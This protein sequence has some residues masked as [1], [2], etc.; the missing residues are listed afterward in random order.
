[1]QPC[2]QPTDAV[3]Y[4]ARVSQPKQKL[5]QQWTIVDTWLKQQGIEIDDHLKYE[6]KGYRRHEAAIRPAFQRLLNYAAEGRLDWVVIASFDRWGVGDVDEFFFYRR[7]LAS[8][9]VR[10]WSVQD[11]LEL[12]S[13]HDNDFWRIIGQAQANTQGMKTHAG[14]NLRKMIEMTL[15]GWHAS[16]QHPYGTDLL[17]CNLSD[18]QPIFRVHLVDKQKKKNVYKIIDCTT[19]QE[20][21]SNTMPSRDCKTTGYRLV[22][23]LDTRRIEAVQL[24]YDTFLQGLT[25]GA[26]ADYLESQGY[27]YFG[28]R[29]GW[30]TIDAILRNPTYTGYL[31]WGKYAYGHYKVLQNGTPVDTP[32]KKKNERVHPMRT[33]EECV[34]SREQIF[35]PLIT[36][37]Q[38]AAVEV[39]LG[40]REGANYKRPRRR[41]QRIH[42]L[43]GL[44]VCPDCD[45]FMVSSWGTKRD[46]TRQQYY[47]CSTYMKSR[48]KECRANSVSVDKLDKAADEVLSKVKTKLSALAA[49]D[50]STTKKL[51]KSLQAAAALAGR[52]MLDWL[53]QILSALPDDLQVDMP[54][55]FDPTSRSEK[56]MQAACSVLP[57][58]L[59]LYEEQYS[60]N[61][62]QARIAE[63]DHEIEKI[64]D[65]MEAAQS[66]TLAKR[67]V[68]TLQKLEQEKTLLTS[69]QD[70]LAQ[71]FRQQAAQASDLLTRLEELETSEVSTL[72]RTFLQKVIPIMHLVE[73]R[74]GKTRTNVQGFNFVPKNAIDSTISDALVFQSVRKG[75]DLTPQ[76]T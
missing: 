52:N 22:H 18:R 69:Q 66:P 14:N 10:L 8:V 20:T 12:T 33:I 7:Q 49:I 5:E 34:K 16:G 32:P 42:P 65:L 38:W 58:I 39:K 41:D 29:W 47:I 76:L 19:G 71:Q 57:K 43:N 26:V 30:N 35:D 60:A 54:A 24:V 28:R 61:D 36:T 48:N 15:Q 59:A 2:P 27:L 4:Y 51:Q 72:W 45:R 62:Q 73:M 25:M 55:D 1:M 13:V 75:R 21:I 68:A 56:N 67:W 46:G 17:C 9:G 3:A 63:I 70:N 40:L 64:G 37:D 53:L 11:Q 50:F 74:N 23:S 44:L 6:D 31:Y